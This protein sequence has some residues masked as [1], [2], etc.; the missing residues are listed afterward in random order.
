MKTLVATVGAIWFI[1]LKT[2]YYQF[3]AFICTLRIMYWKKFVSVKQT[4]RYVKKQSVLNKRKELRFITKALNWNSNDS[5]LRQRFCNLK[6]HRRLCRKRKH[7]HEQELLCK[8]KQL[9]HTDTESL[10][11]LLRQVKGDKGQALQNQHELPSLENSLNY[12][13]HGTSPETNTKIYTQA[14]SPRH[15]NTGW[16]FSRISLLSHRE[17]ATLLVMASQ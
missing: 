8:F 4:I 14:K 12:L 7:K 15:W 9:H 11:K 5:R 6:K 3:K 1:L 16:V 17:K 10:W 13:R 2:K